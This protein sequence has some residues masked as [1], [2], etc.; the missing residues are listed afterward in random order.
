MK[1]IL[2]K[3]AAACVLATIAGHLTFGRAN[4]RKTGNDQPNFTGI[5]HGTL[6][7]GSIKLRLVLKISS[8]ADGSL[9]GTLDSVDQRRHDLPINSITQNGA[10]I[11][12]E[13]KSTNAVYEGKLSSDQQEIIGEWK[14]SSA[15]LPLIFKRTENPFALSRPQE[16]K[17]PYPYQEE[18][19]V[20]ENKKD[21]VTLAG[22]LT[23]PRLEKPVPAVLLITGSGSQDRNE[24]IMG[25]K[26]FLVLADYLT[27]RGIAVLRV[28][29][30][31]VGGSSKGKPTDTNENYADDALVGVEFLKNRKEIDSR[32][33][34]L[35]G[36][37]EGGII[38]SLAAAQSKDVAFVV[39]LASPGIPGDKLLDMRTAR[40]MRANGAS[41]ELIAQTRLLQKLAVAFQKEENPGSQA[42]DSFRAQG[43]RIIK[44]MPDEQKARMS[45]YLK[46]MLTR[47]AWYRYFVAYD[48]RP[49]LK[50][51][52]VSVLA[53]VGEYD[54]QV[55]PKENLIAIAEAL[56]KSGNKD[57]TTVELPRLN[58]HLQTSETG[59]PDE[60]GK[61]EE[62]ISPVALTL[63]ADWILERTEKSLNR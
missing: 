60:Y 20:Y 50:K 39:M 21:K 58:H 23:L 16:P 5:W 49:T 47:P 63:V 53:V 38:A 55:P 52:R 32:K 30:R 57:Y 25:H 51:L 26:P 7:A 40:L 13:M 42:A 29:D 35:I 36:H 8:A 56:K 54:L 28:D 4:Y 12:F 3:F 1:H 2:M 27:R 61:I 18:E 6:D 10:A 15:V 37:S 22:T 45:E 31:G 59:S 24:T 9:V 41:E 62:T 44:E 33:I 11:R 46:L 17:K 34:G 14:Q 48:P 19:V 43:E